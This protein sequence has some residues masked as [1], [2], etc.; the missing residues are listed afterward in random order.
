MGVGTPIRRETITMAE[1]QVNEGRAVNDDH[2][3]DELA[4]T[5]FNK[6]KKE[7]SEWR[8]AFSVERAILEGGRT[9]NEEEG[10][11]VAEL[12]SGGCLDTLAAMRAGFRPVW[13]SEVDKSQARMYEDLTGGMCLGD[14]FGESVSEAERVH[15]VK[16]GQ[17]CVNWARPGDKSGENGE[18][19]WMFVEQTKVILKK[20]PNSFRLEISDYAPQVDEGAAVEKVVKA[21]EGKYVIYKRILQMWRFGDPSNRKRLFLIGFDK[22][23]GQAAHEYLWPK[24]SYDEES[25]PIARMIAVDDG[26]VPEQYWRYDNHKFQEKEPWE[27]EGRADRIQIIARAGVGMGFSKWPNVLRSWDGLLNGPTSFGGGGRGPE[28]DW[29]SGKK[30]RRT[31]LSVPVEYIRAASLPSDYLQWCRK[32]ATGNTDEFVIKCINNGVPQRT[33]VAIDESVMRVLL[34]AKH[35]ADNPRE[36]MVNMTWQWDMF[37]HMLFDTGANGSINFRD[38]EQWM[39][40]ATKSNTRITVANKGSMEVGLDGTLQIT[41]LNTAGY[42]DTEYAQKINFETTTAD[43][44]LELFSFDP[45][46]RDGWGLHCRPRSEMQGKSEIYRPAKGEQ[47]RVSIPL[48]YDWESSRGGFWVDYLVVENP[49]QEHGKLLAAYHEDKSLR[50]C[51]INVQK[52]QW[53]EKTESQAMANE[54]KTHPGVHDVLVAQHDA[55]R[56]VRGVKL[57]LKTDR[58]KMTEKQFHE[59]Y[60]HLGC[61]GD[62]KICKMVKGAARRIRRKV[63]PHKE[64]RAAYKFHMDTVTWGVRSSQGNKYTAVLRDEAS[65]NFVAFTHFLKSDIGDIFSRWVDVIRADPVYH[66]CGYKVCS[67]LCLDNAGEWGE[68]C[69]DWQRLCEDKGIQLIYSCPDRKESSA[70]PDWA[71]GIIEVVTKA[72]LMQNNLPGYWWELCVQSAVFL[73]NRFPTTTL[74]AANSLDGDRPRPLEIYSRFN[75]SRRQI[76]RELSYYLAPGTPALVQTKEKGSSVAPKTRW[77]V[78]I[79]MYRDQVKFMCPHVLSEFRSKS[80]AAFRLKDGLNYLQFLGLPEVPTARGRVSVPTHFKEKVVVQLPAHN[81]E[82]VK[83][84]ERPITEVVL[85]GGLALSPPTITVTEEHTGVLGGKV[86]VTEPLGQQHECGAEASQ[87]NCAQVADVPGS[88]KTSTA[89][90]GGITAGSRPYIDC[91]PS[92]SVQALFDEADARKAHDKRV[93]ASGV[94]T[95]VRTCK[96]MGLPFEQHGIFREWLTASQGFGDE[97]LGTSSYAKLRAGLTLPYPTGEAWNRLKARGSRKQQR[98]DHVDCNEDFDAVQA[99]ESWI[100]D[101]VRD[102]NESVSKGGRF[103]FNVEMS[104]EIIACELDVKRGKDVQAVKKKKVKAVAAGQKPAPKNIKEALYGED[105]E[106]WTKSLNNEFW[107]LVDMGVI[108]LGYTKAELLKEGIDIEKTPVVPVGMYFE[109]KTDSAGEINKHKSRSAIQGHPGNMKKGVHY[110]ETFSA[111]PRESTWRIMCSLV[112]CLNLVRRAFDITKAFCWADLPPGE[113]IALGYPPGFKKYHAE[114]GEELFMILR[115]N[116]YGHPAAGRTFGLA[117]N[118]VIME[119]FNQDGW[120]CERTRSDPCLFVISRKYNGEVQMCWILAHVD[121]CDIIGMEDQICD[122]VVAVCAGIWKITIV[123]PEFM[124]GIRRRVHYASDGTVE[125]VECDMVAFI[126]GMYEAF[127]EHMPTKKVNDPAPPKLHLSKEDK[128]EPGEVTRVLA[129]GYMAAVGMLLWAVR[130]CHPIG[131]AAV[132]MMCRVMSTPSWRAFNAAMQLIAYLYQNRMEGIKFS[133]KGNKTL[134]GFVD[135]SNKPDMMDDGIA[136]WGCVFT[137]MGG[138]ICEISKKL[139]QVGLSS[140]HVEYMAMFYAHQ[141]LVWI[142]QLITEMGLGRPIAAKGTRL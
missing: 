142:R 47:K 8:E 24:P 128:T 140:A 103:C 46:Y 114:T 7:L 22:R 42:G 75:Y 15:Y 25:V 89:K 139:T 104:R 29:K 31:R 68:T 18:T 17:P 19:G 112:V 135:A 61:G 32:Y 83:K 3:R 73:L 123:N 113:L 105:A 70:R 131:K 110:S 56:Q 62:C 69:T 23:L 138:P 80:F 60:G 91:T 77:G 97:I 95:F 93:T 40:D 63:D 34:V 99:T 102:Q 117:R 20:M 9:K 136:Q 52:V 50:C 90:A 121:D 130:H 72:L 26:D 39:I 137:W 43:A 74:S 16:S 28:L 109:H 41:V 78:A 84:V 100:E 133:S 81:Q 119:R 76:D 132:S 127:K 111:T 55:D 27:W 125:S 13:S 86:I 1:A 45:L 58:Q 12:C 33:S 6:I 116:L 67:V 53:F 30:I 101:Q 108:E 126:E 79:A 71:V 118:K 122:E 134:I 88:V 35:R 21:L 106:V 64:T 38:V 54:H 82:P 51:E 124:L 96:L 44:A 14:T 2:E 5:K 129:A 107:G 37:R 57:G 141:Q 11:T 49:K 87:S 10:F 36:M 59:N 115:K 92:V 48:R 94:E 4:A 66:D 120:K 65:D 98:A 85:A